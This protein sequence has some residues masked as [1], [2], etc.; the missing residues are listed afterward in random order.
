MTFDNLVVIGFHK[1]KPEVLLKNDCL[2]SLCCFADGLNISE[3]DYEQVVDV[4]T[5]SWA[6]N[7]SMTTDFQIVD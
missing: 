3:P 2:R 5:P 4:V 6:A 1:F 7:K